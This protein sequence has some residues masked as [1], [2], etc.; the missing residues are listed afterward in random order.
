MNEMDD[1]HKDFGNPEFERLHADTAHV[2]DH[3]YQI[4][5]NHADS[6]GASDGRAYRHL[7][8]FESIA[9]QTDYAHDADTS[10][11]DADLP[12]IKDGL[13]AHRERQD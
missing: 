13:D 1:D 2:I 6:H 7:L 4:A 10:A 12:R 3:A 9:K 5:V 8:K 11:H